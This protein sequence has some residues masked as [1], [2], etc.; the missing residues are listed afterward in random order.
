M[1]TYLPDSMTY[2][3]SMP[4]HPPKWSAVLVRCAVAARAANHASSDRI[5]THYGAAYPT[6]QV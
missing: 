3:T 4:K 5:R 1:L 2:V 6:L